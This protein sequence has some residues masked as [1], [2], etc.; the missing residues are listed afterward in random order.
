MD[1]DSDWDLPRQL[2][3][4]GKVLIG[5]VI[6]LL[7]IGMVT[8]FIMWAKGGHSEPPPEL[9]PPPPTAHALS[10]VEILGINWSLQLLD[11]VPHLMTG[12][13]AEGNLTLSVSLTY[14]GD[15]V[16][17]AGSVTAG[18]DTAQALL[19]QDVVFLKAIPEFWRALGVQVG[20]ETD[21]LYEKWV[22]LDPRFFSGKLFQPSAVVH[23]ALNVTPTSSLDK[24]RYVPFQGSADNATLS[25]NGV[26]HYLV[27]QVDVDVVPL[28][29]DAATAAAAPDLDSRKD[30]SVM[31]GNPGSWQLAPSDQLPGP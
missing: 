7:A 10:D 5:A 23:A 26:S 28:A 6:A 8:G 3:E 14:S 19:D 29:D 16:A 11:T 25:P 27:N 31:T 22:A 4:R 18:R 20:N 1:R 24:N 13:V 21:K 30:W 2:P 17:G 15:R 9:P 12:T